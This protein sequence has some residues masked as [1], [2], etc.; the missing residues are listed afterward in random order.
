MP[1]VKASY[2]SCH[3]LGELLASVGTYNAG[4]D[5]K[6]ILGKGMRSRLI[7]KPSVTA[8]E[9]VVKRRKTL[10]GSSGYLLPDA[11]KAKALAPKEHIM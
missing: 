2:S 10:C 3:A 1:A 11:D 7:D 8:V 9:S 5:G 4:S 6:V